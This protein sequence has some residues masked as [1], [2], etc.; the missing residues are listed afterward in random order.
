MKHRVSRRAE[1]PGGGRGGERNAIRNLAGKRR[2]WGQRATFLEKVAHF[3]PSPLFSSKTRQCEPETFPSLSRKKVRVP[4]DLG[5][6]RKRG[7]GGKRKPSQRLPFASTRPRLR[8]NQRISQCGGWAEVLGEKGNL[9]KGCLLP[10]QGRNDAA[11]RQY[12]QKDSLPTGDLIRLASLRT[13]P[14]GE[15]F[16]T[17]HV[18]AQDII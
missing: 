2:F 16:G 13:F 3:P 7:C 11:G 5:L 10:P 1:G 12:E 15:G 18:P 14:R 9:P 6:E 17:L 4:R 8:T